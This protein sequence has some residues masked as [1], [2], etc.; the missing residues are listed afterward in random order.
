ML[1]LVAPVAAQLSVLLDPAVMLAG[2][3]AK[4]VIVGREAFP[5]AELDAPPQLTSPTQAERRRISVVFAI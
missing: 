3:A 4:E 5:P 2:F 1:M